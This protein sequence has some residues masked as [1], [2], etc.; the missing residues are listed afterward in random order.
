[1]KTRTL[2]VVLAVGV[3]GWSLAVGKGMWRAGRTPVAAEPSPSTT[4]VADK[5]PAAQPAAPAA[6]PAAPAAKPAA[7]G[8][9][10]AAIAQA[11]KA[12]KYL[13]AFFWKED[14]P[15]TLAM[16]KVWESAMKKAADK[17]ES[18][19]VNIADPAEKAIVDKYRLDRAPLPLVLALAPNGAITGGFP[20]Q[21][22]EQDLLD[23][24][25]TPCTERCMKALQEGKLVLLCVQNE[26]SKS[27][28]AAMQGVRAF[29]ADARFE[30]ATEIIVLDPADA[31]EASLLSDLKIDPKESEA[32]TA[33]MAPPGGVLAEFKGATSKDALVSA[34]ENA[35][36][37]GPGGCGP[38]GCGPRK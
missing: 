4:T 10:A 28:E 21:F 35:S 14:D 37:C 25:A 16:R 15:Q 6:Q 27:G 24:F 2:L 33:L 17:A 9:S 18:V 12:G 1:M 7:Q 23:A 8:A 22:E 26:K 29:K 5:A 20:K 30:Q 31:T 34:L 19:A 32:I 11:A 36:T 38:G 3:V 13:F